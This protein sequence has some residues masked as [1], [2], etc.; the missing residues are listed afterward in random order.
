MKT[1]DKKYIDNSRFMEIISDMTANLVEE[2]FGENGNTSDGAGGT[3]YTDEAQDFYNERYDEIESMVH[4]SLGVYSDIDKP[5]ETRYTEDELYKIRENI[6]IYGGSFMKAISIALK[7]A[8]HQNSL[9][10]QKIFAK[11]FKQYLNF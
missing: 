4:I 5:A 11:E 7:V 9:K 1:T 2:R 3:I 8:D 6:G 10:L